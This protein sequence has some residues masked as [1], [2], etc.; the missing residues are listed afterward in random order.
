MKLPQV[1]AGDVSS[2]VLGM[3]GWCGTSPARTTRLLGNEVAAGACRGRKRRKRRG[4][5]PRHAPQDHWVTK[6]SLVR[7]G[8]V[9]DV[10]DVSGVWYVPGTHHKIIG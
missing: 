9:S 1:R 8:D 10:S 5:R 2:C 4:V 6:L 3:R 7:A